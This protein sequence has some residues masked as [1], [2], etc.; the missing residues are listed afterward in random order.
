MRTAF[1]GAL[2]AL[3]FASGAQAQVGANEN[4]GRGASRPDPYVPYPTVSDHYQP[5]YNTGPAPNPF[6]N[7]FNDE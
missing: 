7:G 4:G 3:S 2:V 5:S 6:R 1:L